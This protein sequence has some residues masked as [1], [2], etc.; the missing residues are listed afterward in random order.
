MRDKLAWISEVL[1]FFQHAAAHG[2]DAPIL[3]LRFRALA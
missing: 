1:D 3:W 2:V